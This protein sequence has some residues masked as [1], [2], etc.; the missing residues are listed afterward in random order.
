LFLSPSFF[1]FDFHV[2]I[3]LFGRGVCAENLGLWGFAIVLVFLSNFTI[4]NPKEGPARE[5][6]A[7]V[8]IAETV[9]EGGEGDGATAEIISL[10]SDRQVDA[11]H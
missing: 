3:D 1:T 9:V 4:R 8:I 2:L 7:Y 10:R 6:D 11:T 5:S